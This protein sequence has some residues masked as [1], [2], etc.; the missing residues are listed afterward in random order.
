MFKEYIVAGHQTAFP[1]QQNRVGVDLMG[2]TYYV[3]QTNNSYVQLVGSGIN[4]NVHMTEAEY[5]E[6]KTN[7]KTANR[8]KRGWE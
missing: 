5:E 8:L 1:N 4:V 6:F 2:I 7:L 3:R